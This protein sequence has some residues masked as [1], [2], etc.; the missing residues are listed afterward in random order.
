MKRKQKRPSVLPLSFLC[1]SSVLFLLHAF[2]I[3]LYLCLPR[4]PSYLSIHFSLSFTALSSLYFLPLILSI[5]FPQF[6]ILSHFPQLSIP[7]PFTSPSSSLQP[8]PPLYRL[9]GLSDHNVE[10]GSV[11]VS[12]E[13]DRLWLPGV[14]TQQK[15]KTAVISVKSAPI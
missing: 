1:P 8:S 6:I 7:P 4:L 2:S 10:I 11:S 12:L 9:S 15:S 14:S 5:S 13:T 3:S